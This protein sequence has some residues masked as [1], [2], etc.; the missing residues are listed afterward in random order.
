[1]PLPLLPRLAAC[2]R[3]FGRR[4]APLLAGLALPCLVA[5]SLALP[6]L[7]VLPPFARAV[8]RLDLNPYPAPTAGE[9]RWVIQ[10][11]GV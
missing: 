8:P 6:S 9:Q 1:M 10:L 3:S 11:P 5:P 2:R 7:L 4:L